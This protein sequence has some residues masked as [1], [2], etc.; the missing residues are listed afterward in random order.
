[1]NIWGAPTSQP[2]PD[3]NNPNFIYQ[4]F[5]RGITQFINGSGTFSILLA[6]Y[7]KAIITNQNVPPD[8]AAES[9]ES[10]FSNQYCPGQPLWLCRP[11]ELPATDL[12][13]AF[14]QG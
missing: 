9:A 2:A 11:S 7:L 12:T 14:V 13:F 1:L 3:P 5:Q 4:R 10:N 8:L 6:D